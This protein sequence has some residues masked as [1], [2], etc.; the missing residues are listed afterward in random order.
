M[1]GLFSKSR[2]QAVADDE[3][4][5]DLTTPVDEA[6]YVVLDTELTGLDDRK[7][8]IVSL[9]AIKMTGGRIELGKTLERVVSPE[10]ALT[11]E[12]VLIHGITP[13]ECED[14]PSIGDVLEEFREFCSGCVVV[15]HFVSLDLAFLNREFKRLFQRTLDLPAIDTWRIHTWIQYHHDTAVRHFGE[16]GDKD[17]FSL[18]KKYHIPV[19]KAHDA[20][21]DAFITAQL[22]QRFLRFLPA[23][24]V[25]TVKDLLKIGKP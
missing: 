13:S 23:L 21:G 6:C 12:S 14:K 10:T 8:S 15:G 5:L 16:N 11:S 9:G 3:C 7:D 2:P 20:L 1:L 19:A 18:A 17:L 24:G 25:R 4:R 22:F